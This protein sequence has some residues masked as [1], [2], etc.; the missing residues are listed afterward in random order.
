[1]TGHSDDDAISKR[2]RNVEVDI[3]QLR[4]HV[5]KAEPDWPETERAKELIHNIEIGIFSLVDPYAREAIA[6][7]LHAID[8][9]L[10]KRRGERKSTG[11]QPKHKEMIRRWGELRKQRGYE[12]SDHKID[13]EVAIEFGVT[14]SWVWSVRNN[15][16]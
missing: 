8:R 11:A 5:S 14:P 2:L 4:N 9:K 15:T 10:N 16:H 3:E 13:K 1:M 6:S 7:T 12:T